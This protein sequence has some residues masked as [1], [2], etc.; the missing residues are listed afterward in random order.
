MDTVDVIVIGAGVVGLA[1]ARAFALGGREVLIL[2]A[3]PVV[4]LVYS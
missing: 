4:D 1:V 2:E 3:H